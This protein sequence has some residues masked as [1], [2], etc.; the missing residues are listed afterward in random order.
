MK[1]YLDINGTLLNKD[2][3]PALYLDE[4]IKNVIEKYDVYWLTTHC[5][6]SAAETLNYIKEYVKP[7]TF[8]YM[9]RIKPTKWNVMK[10]EA[11]DLENEFLW[12]DDY[13]FQKEQEMLKGIDKKRCWVAMKLQDNPQQLK[14]Y[15]KI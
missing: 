15:L 2:L 10:I 14:N 4:F 12:F 5:N 8:E 11:V 9:K 3:S 7:E 13:I 6:G 1:I